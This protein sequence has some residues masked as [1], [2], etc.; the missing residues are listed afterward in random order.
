MP[1]Y[2]SIARQA[3]CNY[4]KE[5]CSEKT[6]SL[7]H[8]SM[9]ADGAA[10]AAGKKKELF[11]SLFDYESLLPPGARTVWLKDNGMY[12]VINPFCRQ[13]IPIKEDMFIPGPFDAAVDMG[14]GEWNARL[15]TTSEQ[16]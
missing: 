15:K 6:I 1:N 13:N 7:Y 12:S 8:L 5:H 11:P 4:L 2:R 9:V 10:F 14:P 3:I 16:R